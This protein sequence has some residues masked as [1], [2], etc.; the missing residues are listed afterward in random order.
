MFSVVRKG[1][2]GIIE[3]RTPSSVSSVK[4][5]RDLRGEKRGLGEVASMVKKGDLGKEVAS[6]RIEKVRPENNPCHAF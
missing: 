3:Y 1:N 4:S 5:L 6:G 2:W